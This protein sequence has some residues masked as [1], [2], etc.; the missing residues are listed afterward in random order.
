M[1]KIREYDAR[2]VGKLGLKIQRFLFT[3]IKNSLSIVAV[4]AHILK[5]AP[6]ISNPRLTDKS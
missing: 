4:S 5:I 3:L 1:A 6:W 2:T